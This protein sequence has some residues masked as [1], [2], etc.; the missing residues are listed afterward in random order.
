MEKFRL[1]W[2]SEADADWPVAETLATISEQ[3][4]LAPVDAESAYRKLGFDRFTAIV[5]GSMIGYVISGGDVTLIAFRGTNAGEISDW[6]VNL[7][8]L[9]TD[10]P[11]GPIHKGFY[12]AYQ[13]LKA[14]IVKALG[15]NKP[16]YLWVTGHSLGGAMALVCAYDLTENEKLD[17]RGVITFGQP[18]VARQP[19]AEYL[20]RALLGRYAH[21]VNEADLV[22]RVPPS[23]YRHC[24]SLVWF[25]GDGIKRSK[26]KR[27]LVGATKPG[28]AVSSDEEDLTPL[29]PQEFREAQAEVRGDA[30]PERGPDG[31]PLVRGNAPF[32]LDH[33]MEFYVKKIRALIGGSTPKQ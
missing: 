27:F 16:K 5:E 14:Q 11:Q 23:P 30:V 26:P 31:R 3:A 1:V 2:N 10:T 17:L 7:D 32:L 21:F 29:S 28:E 8:C 15:G 13:S 6:F 20:D 19:L 12:S 18:L 25:K 24:G 33:S 4:Y 22:P 9:S